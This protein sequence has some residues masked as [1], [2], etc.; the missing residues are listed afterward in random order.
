MKIR[1]ALLSVVTWLCLVAPLRASPIPISDPFGAGY[2]AGSSGELGFSRSD[3]LSL[4]RS[5]ISNDLAR[6]E[7]K[8]SRLLTISAGAGR[9][10]ELDWPSDPSP[11]AVPEPGGLM[12]LVGSGLCG[13]AALGR[14]R[15][16]A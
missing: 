16:G 14:R 3:F 9:V 15:L 6:F 12:V 4:L 5:P 13:V 8:R 2:A 10:I 7:L 11:N 1:F